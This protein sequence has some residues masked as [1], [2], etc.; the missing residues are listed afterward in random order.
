MTYI[1]YDDNK[2]ILEAELNIYFTYFL[3]YNIFELLY[4]NI[5]SKNI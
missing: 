3:R 4:Y 5:I 2:N 1:Y